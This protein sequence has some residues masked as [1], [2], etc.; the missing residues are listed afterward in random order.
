[1]ER[2]TTK[3]KRQCGIYKNASMYKAVAVGRGKLLKGGEPRK[4][5]GEENPWSLKA[6]PCNT[7]DHGVDVPRR[8]KGRS[9]ERALPPLSS[10]P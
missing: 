5:L 2:S 1:M 6:A 4:V 9:H 8:P 3:N 10:E 7:N